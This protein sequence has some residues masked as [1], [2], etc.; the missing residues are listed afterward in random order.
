[1]VQGACSGFA[2]GHEEAASSGSK[3]VVCMAE[4]C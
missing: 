3:L 4:S 1:M 2:S